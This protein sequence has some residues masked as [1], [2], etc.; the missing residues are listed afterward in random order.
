MQRIYMGVWYEIA[1]WWY[2]IL[3]TQGRVSYTADN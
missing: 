2:N 3:D 1:L